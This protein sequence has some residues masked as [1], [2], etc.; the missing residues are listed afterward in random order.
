MTQERGCLV[1]GVSVAPGA[2]EAS[3]R[4]SYEAAV[5]VL[6]YGGCRGGLPALG[7]PHF[8]YR[9]R[10]QVS[11]NRLAPARPRHYLFPPLSFLNFSRFVGMLGCKWGRKVWVL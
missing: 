5:W 4:V 1:L 11:S 10:L 6:D 2:F 3:G 8:D 7:A 9:P